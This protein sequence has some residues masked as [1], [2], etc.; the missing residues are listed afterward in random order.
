MLSVYSIIKPPKFGNCTVSNDE[1]PP[2]LISISDLKA[3]YGKNKS[4]YCMYLQDIKK[5]LD[6]VLEN[7]DWEADDIINA[8]ND[9]C[10]TPAPIL[11]CIIYYVTGFSF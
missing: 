6:A 1:S 4:K 10:Y 3:I 7:D 5:K 9:H 11:D 8:N 2:I